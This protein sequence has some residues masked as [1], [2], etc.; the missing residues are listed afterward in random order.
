M[1]SV[2][3]LVGRYPVKNEGSVVVSRARPGP[4]ITAL[5]GSPDPFQ[6]L[7]PD[8]KRTQRLRCHWAVP[9][10][11]CAWQCLICCRK[12]SSDWGIKW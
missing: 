10:W 3:E 6:P 9:R 4:R 5:H 12:A 1:L 2:Q 7:F 8:P 11:P